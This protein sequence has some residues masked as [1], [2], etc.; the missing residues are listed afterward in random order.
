MTERMRDDDIKDI[1]VSDEL[2]RQEASLRMIALGRKTDQKRDDVYRVS[3]SAR[4]LGRIVHIARQTKPEIT[5]DGLIQ[6]CNFD[7]VVQVAKQ[8]SV[9]KESPALN[10][11]RTIGNLL[12]RVC[13][14]KIGAALRTD[15]YRAQQ[16]ATN[17][18]QMVEAKWN[19]R[20]NHVAVRCIDRQ[21]RRKVP[22]IPLTEHLQNFINYILSNIRE[23]SEELKARHNPQDWLQLAKFTMSRLI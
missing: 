16:D 1:V 4:L 21:K 7:V 3:Q 17:L 5:L 23:L 9:D 18:K 6:P 11:G 19:S 10:V 8:M 22:V 12:R 14:T 13:Q 2:I 15:N 20:V